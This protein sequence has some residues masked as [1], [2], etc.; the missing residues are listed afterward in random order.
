MSYKNATS[1]S[2]K[3]KILHF[4]GKYTPGVGDMTQPGSRHETDYRP[5]TNLTS[6]RLL[7][8]NGR[9]PPSKNNARLAY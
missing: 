5:V 4:A 3:L 6:P 9:S 2:S 7:F 8:D 1:S